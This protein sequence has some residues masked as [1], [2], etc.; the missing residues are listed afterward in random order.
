MVFRLC[1]FLFRIIQL[2][3]GGKYGHSCKGPIVNEDV[4]KAVRIACKISSGGVLKNIG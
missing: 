3:T 2:Y 1:Q 4:I